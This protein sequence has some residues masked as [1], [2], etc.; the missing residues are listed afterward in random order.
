MPPSVTG[1]LS[2][3][4]NTTGPLSST[5]STTGP[6]SS[7]A[8]TIPLSN[9]LGRAP[10]TSTAGTIPGMH[11]TS[12][13]SI[14]AQPQAN[15]IQPQI[16]SQTGTQQ[17]K[18]KTT[19]ITGGKGGQ[20]I[21][22]VKSSAPTASLGTRTFQPPLPPRP[23]QAQIRP[24]S[25]SPPSL[26][27]DA[28]GSRDAGA[29]YGAG[30]TR[31]YLA[32]PQHTTMP[33]GNTMQQG[34]LAVPQRNVMPQHNTM[35]QG[36]LAMPQHPQHPQHSAMQLPRGLQSQQQQLPRGLQSQPNLSTSEPPKE[37]N[38]LTPDME[39]SYA[40]IASVLARLRTLLAQKDG[41]LKIWLLKTI[42]P[43]LEVL[44]KHLEEKKWSASFLQR[45]DAFAEHIEQLGIY[46]PDP[47][48]N[49]S[50]LD[51]VRKQGDAILATRPLGTEIEVWMT[52][53]YSLMKVALH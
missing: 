23:P 37:E 1:P 8:T 9:T 22:F 21:S 34:S 19:V 51:S 18:G 29:S 46:S 42:A 40:R 16:A 17:E 26:S 6:L 50:D 49:N 14:T 2:S 20:K 3:T 28:G 39:K 43:K 12:Q 36:N 44:D 24:S 33:Q 11:H 47:I 27:L 41:S 4:L 31:D 15:P 13:Q 38:K 52:A 53:I 7:T 25:L 48:V 35:R 5:L 45:M 10:P 30:I 32:V